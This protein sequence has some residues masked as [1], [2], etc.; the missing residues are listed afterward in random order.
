MPNI[1]LSK[2]GRAW[3]P[4]AGIPTITYSGV[5]LTPTQW[6]DVQEIYAA[7]NYSFNLVEMLG[8]I[9]VHNDNKSLS[10]E[11][12][13]VG[14][15]LNVG[16][17]PMDVPSLKT[18][19]IATDITGAPVLNQPI[20]NL[21]WATRQYTIGDLRNVCDVGEGLDVNV[22]GAQYGISAFQFMP[23]S[24][25]TVCTGSKFAWCAAGSAGAESFKLYIDGRPVKL[26]P[27]GPVAG[28]TQ[29]HQVNFPAAKAEGRL[30][31][32]R[33]SDGILGLY[34]DKPYDL[35]KPPPRR[36]PRLL[37]IG[38]SYTSNAGATLSMDAAYW[39]IGPYVGS[40]DTWID[41][42]GS[43]GYDVTSAANGTDA[44]LN[45]YMHR[46]EAITT[47]GLT[48]DI[49][50]IDPDIVHTHGGFANDLL[51]G[52]SVAEC[53]SNGIEYYTR[54]R[55]RAPRAKLSYAEGF[56]PPAFFNTFNDEYIAIR[57]ALQSALTRVGVYYIDVATSNPWIK[58]LGRVG[59]T[60]A[61]GEN[62]NIFISADGAHPSTEGHAMIR[63]RMGRALRTIALDDGRRVNTLI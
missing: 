45:S 54:L 11:L 4:G 1:R 58:G 15:A 2:P 50:A 28:T 12:L 59:A 31:E 61:D 39:D 24:V 63:A 29:F 23:R 26:T 36:G 25:R 13:R 14:R 5:F 33:T 40:E 7:G 53:I 19:P 9:P 62:A 18:G 47:N 34:T 6:A 22:A 37:V 57:Q 21:A 32:I 60:N 48:W 43:S 10:P 3:N 55:E 56:A 41:Y 20:G 8:P 52:K 42:Q 35:Y 16:R 49:E 17:E 44:P 51:R 30:I 38:D 46:L 27:F